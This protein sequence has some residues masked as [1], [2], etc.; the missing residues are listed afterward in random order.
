MIESS[1]FNIASY[2]LHKVPQHSSPN[3]LTLYSSIKVR[4]PFSYTYKL[5]GKIIFLSILI[6]TFLNSK[7]VDKYSRT[8]RIG[9]F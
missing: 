8:K 7:P 2:L 5:M 6:F 3:N 1:D 4:D 9:Y